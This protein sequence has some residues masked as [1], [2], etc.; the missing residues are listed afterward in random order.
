VKLAAIGEAIA[1][2]DPAT[3]VDSGLLKSQALD[4]VQCFVSLQ[5][6]SR[7]RQSKT[8]WMTTY[9]VGI[10]VEKHKKVD[11][12]TEFEARRRVTDLGVVPAASVDAVPSLGDKA[13]AIERALGNTELRVVEGG[14]VLSLSLAAVP[15]YE[16]D[17]ASG[18]I[19]DGPSTPDLSP[20]QPAMVKDMRDL[21]GRLKH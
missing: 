1:P 19:G 20:Y 6:D 2:K 8:G 11:P 9:T 17:G 7:V 14:T 13:Y 16:G 4:Q 18:D 15:H 5:P 12:R 3:L 10:T 21:M